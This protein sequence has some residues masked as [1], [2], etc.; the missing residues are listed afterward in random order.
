MAEICTEDISCTYCEHPMF[1][2]SACEAN[3]QITQHNVVCVIFEILDWTSQL[4][5]SI[6]FLFRIPAIFN[7]EPRFKL[8]LENRECSCFK[9]LSYSWQFHPILYRRETWPACA[10][11]CDY[12]PPDFIVYC[13]HGVFYGFLVN[14]LRLHFLGLWM[15]ILFFF[16]C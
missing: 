7:G 14:V 13:N 8:T 5:L 9:L 10:W 3:G 4:C 15:V 12:F 16:L 11:G 1:G 6:P 2:K